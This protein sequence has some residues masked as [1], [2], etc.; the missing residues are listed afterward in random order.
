MATDA[1]INKIKA[2]AEHD[3]RQLI[4]DAESRAKT[5]IAA[6]E[7]E[8]ERAAASTEAGIAADI[9]ALKE[10]ASLMTRLDI[11][12][13]TLAAEREVLDQV[14]AEAESRLAGLSDREKTAFLSDFI[15]R[16]AATGKEKL[17]VPEGEK[18]LYSRGMMDAVNRALKARGLPGELTLDDVP[19]PFSNGVMLCGEHA[20]IN[21]DFHVIIDEARASCER[22]VAEIL[23]HH[24]VS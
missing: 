9:A 23:F 21:G 20:D 14:F 24:E 1:I 16:A 15:T 3:A 7:K 19:A 18:R 10:R 22:E 5:I 2:D 8:T 11:R 12:K 13:Q 4:T 17:R 6:G